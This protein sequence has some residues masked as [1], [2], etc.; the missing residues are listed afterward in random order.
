MK[1]KNLNYI[2]VSII[3]ILIAVSIFTSRNLL[4][5]SNIKDITYILSDGFL[6]PGVLIIGV[7]ILIIVSNGGIFDIFTYSLKKMRATKMFGEK[8]SQA[9]NSFYDYRVSKE[10]APF[11]FLI[12]VGGVFFGLSVIFNIM[13]YYV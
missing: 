11:G 8:R 1:R 6:L 3:G 5:A 13:F 9:F 2:I 4:D 7:G 10:K 12:I